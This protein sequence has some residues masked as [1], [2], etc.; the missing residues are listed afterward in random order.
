MKFFVRYA[1]KIIIVEPKSDESLQQLI[2]LMESERDKKVF[3][4]W[5]TER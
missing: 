4:Y 2:D 5:H 1:E 3:F